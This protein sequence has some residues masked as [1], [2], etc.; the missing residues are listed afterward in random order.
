VPCDIFQK[1]LSPSSLQYFFF[2]VATP[3]S[4]RLAFH[5][6][7][8]L[9]H[10]IYRCSPRPELLE[11]T[12]I[13]EKASQRSRTTVSPA[14]CICDRVYVRMRRLLAGY[15]DRQENKVF[16]VFACVQLIEEGTLSSY[17]LRSSQPQKM[18]YTSVCFSSKYTIPS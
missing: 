15:K 18:K 9:L 7:G 17:V 8:I 11:M 10:C 14:R 16:T 1:Q 12:R 3:L 4:E 6:T 13:D 5:A 2:L